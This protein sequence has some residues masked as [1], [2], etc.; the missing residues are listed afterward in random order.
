M[1]KHNANDEASG[2]IVALEISNS[3]FIIIENQ[4]P[5]SGEYHF[6][7]NLPLPSTCFSAITTVPFSLFF[8]ANSSAKFCVELISS[9]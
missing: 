9:K 7:F 6:R 2:I 1:A 8:V 4:S 5:P 3:G